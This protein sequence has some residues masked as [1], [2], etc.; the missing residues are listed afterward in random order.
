MIRH[1]PLLAGLLLV[2]GVFE[3]LIGFLFVLVG[4]TMVAALIFGPEAPEPP[5]PEA[6]VGVGVG[7]VV[8]GLVVVAVGL[9]KLVGAYHA[10]KYRRRLL[11]LVAAASGVVG[12]L[13]CYCGVTGAALALYGFLVLVSNTVVEAFRMG[14]SGRTPKEITAWFQGYRPDA[15][16]D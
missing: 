15:R 13:T 2:Q 1:V 12:V 3:L 14:E 10:F 7:Y 8:A 6:M 5:A 16:G 4:P 11:V 9:L